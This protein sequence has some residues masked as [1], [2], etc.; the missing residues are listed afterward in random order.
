M[1]TYMGYFWDRFK[2]VDFDYTAPDWR[3]VR[4]G[5][6]F[7]G[8]CKNMACVA[9]NDIVIV[10]KGFYDDTNGRCFVNY[11]VE[12]L[13]CPMCDTKLDKTNVRDV[14][15]YKCKLEVKTTVEGQNEIRYEVESIDK[16][17]LAESFCVDYNI[18]NQAIVL[19][20]KRL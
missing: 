3:R 14:G 9:N 8:T 5:L 16:Y 6:N 7:R 20:V 10:P 19:I 2:P 17:R 18:K 4:K 13:E 15:I 1:G 12:Q 11:E